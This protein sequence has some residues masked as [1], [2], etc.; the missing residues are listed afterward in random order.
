VLAGEVNAPSAALV[1]VRDGIA[2]FSDRI[3]FPVRPMVGVIGTAPSGQAVASFYPGPHGGNLDINEIAAGSTVYL[4]VAVPGALLAIGDVHATMGDG[5]LTGGGIDIPAVVTVQLR[6]H[7]GVGWQRP[8]V[9]TPEAWST[10]GN[11]ASLAEAIR[12][13]TRDMVALLS[14]R[15]SISREEGFLLVGVAGDAR[16]GQAAELGMDVTAYVR[17]PKLILPRAW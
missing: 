3:R 2:C 9:E 13:A 8:V 4:P 14:D 7:K 12:I 17:I 5:E 16:I 10:C 15:L 11:A 1:P 6:S